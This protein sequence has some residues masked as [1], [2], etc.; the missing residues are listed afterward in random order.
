MAKMKPHEQEE[1]DALY[2]YVRTNILGYDKNQSLSRTMVLRLKGL[3]SNKFIENNNVKATAN[4]SFGIV[5]TTF[6]FCSVDIKRGLASTHFSDENHRFNY[7]IKIVESNLNTVYMRLKAKEK[8]NEA[9]SNL[10]IETCDTNTK[11]AYKSQRTE[12]KGKKNKYSN[13]W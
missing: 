6:K 11:S 13:L 2:E 8:A 4:Y 1:W 3:T 7:I 5:L 9:V 10:N 12:N